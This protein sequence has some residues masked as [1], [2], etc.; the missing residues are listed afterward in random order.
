MIQRRL[1][2]SMPL[3]DDQ[4]SCEQF[5]QLKKDY[6]EDNYPYTAKGDGSVGI[7]GSI[8]I[9]DKK[10]AIMFIIGIMEQFNI[11]SKELDY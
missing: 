2:G 9:Q 11:D 1:D 5:E 6:G 8:S 4:M 7:S 3:R 10:H